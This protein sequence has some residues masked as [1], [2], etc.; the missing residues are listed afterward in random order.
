M[1]FRK[2]NN[3]KEL[4]NLSFELAQTIK[5]PQIVLLKGELAVGK[6]QLVKY[7]LEN[8]GR[9]GKEVKSPTFSL[10]NSYF[11]KNK[12]DIHHVDLY[13][14]RFDQ[15]LHEIAFWDLFYTKSLIFIEWPEKVEKQ[16]PFLWNKLLIKGEFSK[17]KE[18]RIFKWKTL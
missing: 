12:F 6:T 9:E 17:N 1:D 18:E 16:L 2:I 15:E 5:I 4:K 14:I 13:R 3:L 7:M 11:Q 8:L 10:I